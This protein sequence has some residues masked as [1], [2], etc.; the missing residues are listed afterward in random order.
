[1]ENMTEFVRI[2]QSIIEILRKTR[3]EKGLTLEEAAR[4]TATAPDR[5]ARLESGDL[6]ILPPAY[7]VALLR[8]YALALGAYEEKLFHEMKAAAGIP[9]PGSH[10]P[11]TATK[12]QQQKKENER[13][14]MTRYALLGAAAM[15]LLIALWLLVGRSCQGPSQGAGET[16]APQPPPAAAST[17]P[18]PS[19]A[20]TPA[21]EQEN[22]PAAPHQKTPEPAVTHSA[23]VQSSCFTTSIDR[24]K[25]APVDRLDRIPSKE[26]AITYFSDILNP[27]GEPLYHE[28]L[29]NGKQV[30]RIAV[31]T[32]EGKRWRCWSQKTAGRGES[33][34][35]AVRILEGDGRVLHTDSIPAGTLPAA[36]E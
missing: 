17:A 30:Q 32:P 31:G 36:A 24:E 23:T 9:V 26:T 4:M 22:V 35:W 12:P 13:T 16:P 33:G 25:R 18:P 7:M 19:P 8:E 3:E 20:G 29:F 10:R 1:M 34:V 28:W 6:E 5:L 14:E 2:G 27:S 11:R 21:P 15:A